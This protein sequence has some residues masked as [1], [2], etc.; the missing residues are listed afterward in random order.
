MFFCMQR[1]RGAISI[2]VKEE[3]TMTHVRAYTTPE[4][5][6]AA[7]LAIDPDGFLLEPG[8]WDRATAQRLADLSGLGPLGQTHWLVIGFM[9]DRYLGSGALPSM[10]HLCRKLG[11]EKGAVKRSFGTCRTAWQIAGLPNPGQEALAY[12]A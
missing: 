4:S 7:G 2:A 3:I 12:M 11:V 5:R 1:R 10:R 8:D 9:R 6:Q